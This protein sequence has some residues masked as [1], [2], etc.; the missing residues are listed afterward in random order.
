MTEQDS[1]IGQS[2]KFRRGF[3]FPKFLKNKKVLIILL[4]LIIVLSGGYFVYSKFTAG[5]K[6]TVVAAKTSIVKKGDISIIT[7][8]DGSV[9]AKDGVSLSFS[10]TGLKINNVF[11]KEGDV[12]KKGDKIAT[13][14]TGTQSIDLGSAYASYNSAKASYAEKIAGPTE[15]DLA[16]YKNSVES[17]QASLDKTLTQNEYSIKSAENS[18]ET[19]KDNLKLS[20]GGENSQIVQDAYESL[21]NSSLSALTSLNSALVSADN[22]LGID[23]TSANDIFES[24]L[25]ALDSSKINSAK[26]SYLVAKEKLNKAESALIP[27]N[28]SSNHDDIMAGA[29]LILDGL[30]VMHQHYYDL[31]E[32][33]LSTVPIGDLTQSSLD[34][35]R[36]SVNSKKSSLISSISSFNS[37]MKSVDTA[38]TSYDSYQRSYQNALD[39]L[40]K[41]KSD[42]T[43]SE[44]SARLSL[45]NVEQ[46][47]K[48]ASS[49]LTQAELNSAK[50]SLANASA[51][52]QKL[53]YQI[54]QSTLKSPIDGE[55]VLLNGK[56]GDIIV[57]SKNSPF[58]TILNK[59]TFFVETN[60]EESE[61]SKIQINQKAHITIDSLDGA[62]LDGIVNFVSLT[63]ES[64]NGG[65]VTYLVR[66][67][68]DNTSSVD[69][70]EGMSASVDFVIAE[71]LD[72]LEIP[73]QAV[74]NIDG[75][76]SV[77][78][79][80]GDIRQVVTGFTDGQMVEI[81]SGLEEG[82]KIKY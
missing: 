66:V 20:E 75:K 57:E 69:I 80:N 25:S 49:P 13:A 18:V 45:K 2:K 17:A 15:D 12:V 1:L 23:N 73:V 63:S 60:I 28:L 70:R 8:S 29:K 7:N 56:S 26:N 10:S 42:A 65:V 76:P 4:A 67:L 78:L 46:Q 44:I 21:Y 51:S 77:H 19:A 30:T 22:I 82:E 74:Q 61:I 36:S 16:S 50:S 5:T 53:L 40:E 59:G 58:V 38:K 11:V 34:S 14:D 81:I 64:G 48:D 55:V 9:V 35:M 33:L 43:A 37:A 24:V 54:D 32:M 3:K 52:V 41:A 47:L 72:V 68:L 6:K 71:A 27:L 31:Q 39:A 79:E 62:V